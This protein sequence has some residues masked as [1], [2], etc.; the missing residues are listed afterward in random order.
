LSPTSITSKLFPTCSSL[1]FSVSSFK[2]R[3]LIHLDLPRDAGMVKFMK[4]HHH[5][6]PYKQ[7]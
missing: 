3:F 4:I 6:P 1:W 2:L 5:N 7:T